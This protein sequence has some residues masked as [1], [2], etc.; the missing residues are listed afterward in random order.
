[1]PFYIV[2]RSVW[3][4]QGANR[5]YHIN[6][7][8]G[9]FLTAW[10]CRWVLFVLETLHHWSTLCC[11]R[12][13][14]NRQ[15]IC[16]VP[17]ARFVFIFGPS[18]PFIWTIFNRLATTNHQFALI[19][20]FVAFVAFTYEQWMDRLIVWPQKWSRCVKITKN[21]EVKGLIFHNEFREVD[22]FHFKYF[23]KHS[24]PEKEF[25]KSI[26]SVLVFARNQKLKWIGVHHS[27]FVGNRK[28]KT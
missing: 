19:V 10:R 6:L 23:L 15:Q 3:P 13:E 8:L 7:Y 22:L 1:M 11:Y 24:L 17:L 26:W 16:S 9:T 28:H 21:K 20:S 4:K 25:N 5:L 12:M 27:P 18:T 14:T 2:N